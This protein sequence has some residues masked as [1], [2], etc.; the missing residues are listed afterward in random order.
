MKREIQR[1]HLIA[2]MGT[3]ELR[4]EDRDKVDGNKLTLITLVC[5]HYCSWNSDILSSHTE[6]RVRGDAV[7]CNLLTGRL[8]QCCTATSTAVKMFWSI[9][10]WDAV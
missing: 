6:Q 10:Q 7:H 5:H 9:R 3:E 1:Y 8:L 2:G 4:W